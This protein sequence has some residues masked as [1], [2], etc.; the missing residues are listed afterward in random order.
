VLIYALLGVAITIV[1]GWAGQISLGHFAL[2]GAGAYLT[3]RLSPH[4]VSIP[5]LLFLSGLLGAVIMIIVGLPALRIRGLT[6]AVTTLGL[7]PV[8]YEWLFKQN[9]FG[10]S[11]S[12]GLPVTTP[13]LSGLGHPSSRLDVYY[14][15]LA[16]LAVSLLA[17]AAVRRSLPGRMILAVRDNEAAAEAFGVT[18]ATVKLAALAFSGF[19]AGAGGVLW[20]DAWQNLSLS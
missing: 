9:W 19:I 4:G 5:L 11:R 6:L 3:A 16:V 17:A 18:P 13:G 15:S 12:Y 10:S 1:V 20:A 8:S 14:L 7:G 2:I